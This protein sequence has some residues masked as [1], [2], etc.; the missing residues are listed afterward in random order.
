MKAEEQDDSNY[1]INRPNC[2][3]VNESLPQT[4]FKFTKLLILSKNWLHISDFS[5]E[6]LFHSFQRDTQKYIQN[7]S[8]QLYTHHS[9]KTSDRLRT[10]IQIFEQSR[11]IKNDS[12]PCLGLLLGAVTSS[13]R[14]K[15]NALTQIKRP[16]DTCYRFFA[17]HRYVIDNDT[18]LSES[19]S[20]VKRVF[21]KPFTLSSKTACKLFFCNKPDFS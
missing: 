6:A 9:F 13:V 15:Q 17:S 10:K 20:R 3:F 21:T 8:Y 5:Q 11:C 14:S 4:L 7:S 16:T 12:I 2:V 1:Y 19:P 18:N